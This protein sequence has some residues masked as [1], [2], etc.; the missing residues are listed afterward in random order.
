LIVLVALT[1][2][3]VFWITAWA[4]GVKSFDAFM[5]MA[6]LTVTAA[7]IRLAAPFARQLMGR[8]APAPDQRGATLG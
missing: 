8:E 4:F 7:G 3:A 6:L 1:V 5:V 2:G